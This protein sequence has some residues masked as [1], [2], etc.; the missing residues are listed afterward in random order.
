MMYLIKQASESINSSTFE[1]KTQ[2]SC[3]VLPKEAAILW[4]IVYKRGLT[5]Y[6]RKKD[7]EKYRFGW[8]SSEII[9]RQKLIHIVLA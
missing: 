6:L 2:A 7:G 4:S 9:D 3:L 5:F 8:M 1:V